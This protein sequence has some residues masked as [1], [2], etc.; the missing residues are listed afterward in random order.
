MTKYYVVKLSAE[1]KN[2]YGVHDF[3]SYL[4]SAVCLIKQ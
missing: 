1:I 3:S 4:Y 2:G